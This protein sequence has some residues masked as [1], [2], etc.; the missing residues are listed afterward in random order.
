MAAAV[1]HLRSTSDLLSVDQFEFN[2]ASSRLK[3]EEVIKWDPVILN[4]LKEATMHYENKIL[5]VLKMLLPELEKGG[6]VQ[7][8]SIFGFGDYNPSC[9]RLVTAMNQE[10][11]NKA[12]INNMDPER[13]VGLINY[14]LG[15]YGRN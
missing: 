7:R 6:F 10:Q 14:S 9:K 2:F 4:S 15:L 3:M 5:D 11:L 8:G 1:L 13:G 12:P